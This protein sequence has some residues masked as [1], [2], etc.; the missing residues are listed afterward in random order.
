MSKT[1]DRVEGDEVK[2][3]KRL[4]RVLI[5]VLTLVIIIAITVGLYLVYGRHPERLT[6][7]KN[8]AYWGAFLISLIGNASVI[9]PGVVLPILSAIGIVLYTTTGLIGPILIGLIGGIGAAIGEMTSYMV[10]YSGHGIIKRSKL[11]RRVE[12]WMRRWGTVTIF[13]LSL[14]PFFFDLVGIA[15]G[16]LRFPPWKFFLLCWSGRTLLY[17]SFI[18]L[19]TIWGWETL[20]PYF[21]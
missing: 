10:G 11:Y 2:G 21:S 8:Y 6:E 18:L 16:A 20:L 15:A 7:L 12:G 17:V 9:L 13:V 4:K 1:T 5:P 3:K 14:V 19:T